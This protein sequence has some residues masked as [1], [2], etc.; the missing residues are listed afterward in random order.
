MCGINPYISRVFDKY[1]DNDMV[2]YFLCTIY[3]FA[4]FDSLFSAQILT[5]SPKVD[6]VIGKRLSL[7]NNKG[8]K[9]F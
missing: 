4:N 6:M 3:R 7:L 1:I 9:S 2:Q 8:S 5:E